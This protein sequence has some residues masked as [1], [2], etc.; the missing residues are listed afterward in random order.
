VQHWVYNSKPSIMILDRGRYLRLDVA[1]RTRALV[2]WNRPVWWPLVAGLLCV[3]GLLLVAVR[4]FQR[5][6]RTNA[7]G[8]VLAPV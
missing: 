2:D 3:C 4:S 5:R 1:E 6:E 8:E 7:R